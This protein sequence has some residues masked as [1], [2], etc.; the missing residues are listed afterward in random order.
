MKEFRFIQLSSDK[1]SI[2]DVE[3]FPY[4]SQ[5]HWY[6]DGRYAARTVWNRETKKETKLYMHKDLVKGGLVDHINGNKLDN[7]LCNLR[8]V[9]SQQNHMNQLVQNKTK[10]SK[11]K[12]VSWDKSRNK[13]IAYC[14]KDGKMNNLGRFTEEK[15]AALAYNRKAVEIFGEFAKL[16]EVE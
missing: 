12:G 16:N 1:K 14:K 2:V 10:H 6:F 8:K 7:R 9:S 5:F 4:L 11:Y 13:W 3:L 15:E